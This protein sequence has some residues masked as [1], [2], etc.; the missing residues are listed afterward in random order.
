MEKLLD[1]N[2][3]VHL[4]KIFLSVLNKHARL[5]K[6]IDYFRKKGS[7]WLLNTPLY[8]NFTMP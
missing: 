7:L 8:V 2:G 3:C 4:K 5:K 1:I 6:A